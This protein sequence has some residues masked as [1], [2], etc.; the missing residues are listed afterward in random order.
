MHKNNLLV[1]S[2][3][4]YTLLKRKR[5]RAYNSHITQYGNTVYKGIALVYH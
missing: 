5:N 3:G 2:A 1:P 4:T